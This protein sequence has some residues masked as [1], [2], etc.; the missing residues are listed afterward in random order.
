MHTTRIAPDFKEFLR[1][2]AAHKVR[3]LLIGG[4]VVNAFGLYATQ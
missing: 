1:L 2:F 4:Y 3:F